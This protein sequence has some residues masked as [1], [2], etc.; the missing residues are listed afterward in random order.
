MRGSLKNNKIEKVIMDWYFTTNIYI[1]IYIR[2]FNTSELLSNRWKFSLR[3][4][5]TN[6]QYFREM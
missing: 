3:Y 5:I 4:S 6:M 1:T 2:D